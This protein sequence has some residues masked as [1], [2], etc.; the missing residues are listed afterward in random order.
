ME[1]SGTKRLR[2]ALETG[3]F[4]AVEGHVREFQRGDRG[5]HKEERFTV[6]SNG[7]RYT[8]AY[9][10]SNWE[11]GFR[12]SHGPIREGFFVRI[13]DVDGHIARLEIA[14]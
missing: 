6:V 9:T 5:G 2:D 10:S 12:Q 14:N 4:T 1:Y 8:Y 11:P 7:R 13:A 3:D